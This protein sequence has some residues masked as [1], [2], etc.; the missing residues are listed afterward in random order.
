MLGDG[1]PRLV[2]LIYRYVAGGQP[3]GHIRGNGVLPY[4]VW[5]MDGTENESPVKKE[6]TFWGNG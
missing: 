5:S 2:P 6:G 1:S 3:A 4:T